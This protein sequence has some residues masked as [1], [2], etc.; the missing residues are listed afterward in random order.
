M[1]AGGGA[2]TS[3]HPAPA[4]GGAATPAGGPEPE[5]RTT[6]RPSPASRSARPARRSSSTLSTHT[7][8]RDVI[9]DFAARMA[10]IEPNRSRWTGP[11]AVI[12]A[13]SGGSQAHSSAISPGPNVPISATSTSVPGTRRSLT[14]RASPARL[15]KLRGLATTAKRPARRC[16]T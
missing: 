11:T 16:A 14:V 15:L 3:G 1:A 8:A 4:C 9:S 7:S 2:A 10:S 12:T 6:R 5:Q 13:T